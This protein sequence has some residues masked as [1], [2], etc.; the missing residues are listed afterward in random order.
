MGPMY[1]FQR[2]SI[3]FDKSTFQRFG[4]DLLPELNRQ[5]FTIVP[6][7]L[8]SEIVADL[9]KPDHTP[10]QCRE[11]VKVL[12]GKLASLN[13]E[14]V[15]HYSSLFLHNLT[16]D[17]ELPNDRSIPILADRWRRIGDGIIVDDHPQ[18]K[19]VARLQ[20]GEF[21]DEDFKQTKQWRAAW[22]S[23]D[24]NAMTASL[25]GKRLSP[26]NSIE[27]L[28][29]CTDRTLT[30]E[31]IGFPLF[32]RWVKWYLTNFNVDPSINSHIQQR[33]Q[34]GGHTSIQKFST[35]AY[36][37]IRCQML[38]NTGVMYEQVKRRPTN[39]VDVEY[40]YYTPFAMVFSSNDEFHKRLAPGVIDADQS[41]VVGDTLLKE[42]SILAETRTTDFN[43]QPAKDSI[44]YELQMKHVGG[45]SKEW[46]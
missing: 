13:Y 32:W 35:Y 28:F 41:F 40:L 18:E 11:I 37:C 27:T 16:G 1:D 31:E 6:P 34:S 25:P 9:E 36:H 33:W 17:Y 4:L 45:K 46:R 22:E 23:V 10:D 30:D 2:P 21:T 44:I 43:V 8:L 42:V 19:M 39:I 14:I 5:F 26:I 24:Y 20:R 15:P 7:V 38:A 12:S 3:L 29:E